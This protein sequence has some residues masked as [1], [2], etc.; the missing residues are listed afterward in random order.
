[1][2]MAE[3]DAAAQAIVD[4]AAILMNPG[5]IAGPYPTGAATRTRSRRRAH[6]EISISIKSQL[7]T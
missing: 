5:T 1:M 6:Q 2:I 7:H 3:T 4:W